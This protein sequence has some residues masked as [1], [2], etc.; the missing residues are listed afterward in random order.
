MARLWEMWQPGHVGPVIAGIARPAL[1]VADPLE[2]EGDPLAGQGGAAFDVLGHRSRPGP[3]PGRRVRQS[4]LVAAGGP[5]QVV[6]QHVLRDEP[7]V[8]VRGRDVPLAGDG[9]AG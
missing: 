1:E 3:G 7:A 2:E 5:A 6:L 4:L 9:V 8:P